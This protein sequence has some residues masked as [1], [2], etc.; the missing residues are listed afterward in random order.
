MK[1]PVVVIDTG[2]KKCNFAKYTKC[3]RVQGYLGYH[4]I[5][6]YEKVLSYQSQRCGDK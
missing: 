5:L 1:S 3:I 6:R 2:V 4:G